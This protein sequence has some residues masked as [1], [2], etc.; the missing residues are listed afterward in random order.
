VKVLFICVQPPWPSRSGTP[1]RSKGWI[2]A[3][4]H[5]VHVGLVV[6][7]RSQAEAELAKEA[8]S[9]CDY[10]KIVLDPLT[11]QQKMRSRIVAPAKLMPFYYEEYSSPKMQ[12]AVA[13]ALKEWSPDVVQAEWIGS[14]R[15]LNAA[16]SQSMPCIYS[17]HNLEHLVV[18]GPLNSVRR[19]LAQPFIR[20]M[21]CLE[22]SWASRA[23]SIIA[24]A[25]KEA[26]WF[27]SVNQN[28]YY[29]PNA[30]N[31]GAYSFK[32]PLKRQKGPVA[33]I[34][35][36]SYPPNRNA[37]MI[38]ARE[39]YP[40]LRKAHRDLKCLIAGMSADRK[41]LSLA[42]NGIEVK[43]DVD[44]MSDIW[45][46]ISLLLCPLRWGAGSR[47][48]LLEAAA[49]GVPII[50]TPISAEGLNFKPNRDYLI[51][52]SPREMVQKA[53]VLLREPVR[54]ESLAH[55]ARQTL[56]AE[57]DWTALE[58]DLMKIYDDLV[59]KKT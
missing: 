22:R 47:I 50:A 59:H 23:T 16:L 34:G 26:K 39:V 48:K 10:V 41:I 38:L 11:R 30:I 7:T 6:L 15:Y 4:G 20:R 19:R 54:A 2:E 1:L 29:I 12:I 24:V 37:A 36:L 33:F 18:A 27:R 21:A 58:P 32:P 3:V 31:A 42:G 9:Y 13:R 40:E 5:F 56:L 8:E 44:D 55:R 52:E 51:A 45:S 17:A 35:H 46:R 28:T 53:S 14:V 43:A 57:H 49:C 25:E